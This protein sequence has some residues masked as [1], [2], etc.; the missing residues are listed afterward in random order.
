MLSMAMW[1]ALVV[2]PAQ[3]LIGDM[4][5]LNGLGLMYRDGLGVEKDEAA[6]A[7]WFRKAA[8]LGHSGAAVDLGWMYSNLGEYARAIGYF[9]Q[10]ASIQR[11][12]G[13]REGEALLPR[14]TGPGRG[15]LEEKRQGMN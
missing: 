13:N 3:A 10:A 4:H 5:G 8:D 7:Q 9:E 1:M 11:E 15:R 2:A 6:A 14:A 12:A